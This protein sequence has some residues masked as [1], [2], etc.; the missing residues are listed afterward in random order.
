MWQ[1]SHEQSMKL[2]IASI[3]QT[4]FSGDAEEVSVPGAAGDMTI[5][6]HHTPLISTL[7]PGKIVVRTKD[8]ES[9][10]FRITHGFLEVANGETVVL[11]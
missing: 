9:S 5:L 1:V 11:L 6:P 4:L 7:R 10:E 3:D 2:T 8:K